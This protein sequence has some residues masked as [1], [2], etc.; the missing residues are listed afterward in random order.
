MLF[1]EACSARSLLQRE[2]NRDHENESEQGFSHEGS[3]L[4]AGQKLRRK[5]VAV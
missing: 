4:T 2:Q 3:V 1:H 5:P